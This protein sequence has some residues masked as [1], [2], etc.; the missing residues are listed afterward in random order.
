MQGLMMDFPLTLP[1]LFR[2]A[3]QL[4]ADR[5]IVSR[6]ADRGVERA[7][8]GD[9]LRRARRLALALRRLG[10]RRGDRV[11]TLGWNHRRHLEAYFG[12]PWMGAVLH[13]LNPRLRPEELGYVMTHA[14]DA[15]LLVDAPLVP[16]WEQVRP[17]AP[18]VRHVIVMREGRA[19]DASGAAD[20]AGLLDYE[21]L[22]DAED[23]GAFEE[24]ALD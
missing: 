11:A 22:L 2:R 23:P 13:T 9:A 7:T 8:Y 4:Y 15:V 19:S 24:P 14:E 1:A 16:L 6:R 12:V 3:E 20:A 21:A 17:H 18:G 10:V 5:P